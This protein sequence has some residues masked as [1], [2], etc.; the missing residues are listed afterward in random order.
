MVNYFRTDFQAL[1]PL[2]Q[3]SER[4]LISPT[5]TSCQI[6]AVYYPH[7][8]ADQSM[9][10][11]DG[12]DCQHWPPPG[13]PHP[14]N[15]TVIR[16]QGTRSGVLKDGKGTG[17]MA[18]EI[19]RIRK[20]YRASRCFAVLHHYHW[21]TCQRCRAFCPDSLPGS[22]YGSINCGCCSAIPL[23]HQNKFQ[24]QIQQDR[25]SWSITLNG[26][27]TP[28]GSIL[29][30]RSSR[31]QTDHH[32]SKLIDASR[33]DHQCRLSL[34]LSNAIRIFRTENQPHDQ[35]TG[36]KKAARAAFR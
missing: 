20:L 21:F 23:P 5:P 11:T 6:P 4:H 2:S 10:S 35:T 8:Y 7:Q 19:V 3:P 17:G 14:D 16:Q 22:S 25:A 15:H 24:Q 36:N 29:S 31:M 12:E 1:L 28:A 26:Y 27:N 9:A 32:R 13:V 33:L 34:V 18:Q 30:I